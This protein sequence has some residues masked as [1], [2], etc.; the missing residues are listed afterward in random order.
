MKNVILLTS[1]VFI[2]LI[3]YCHSI[4]HYYIIILPFICDL[5][6]I[7]NTVKPVVTSIKGSMSS[8]PFSGHLY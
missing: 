5:I 4:K 2:E 3:M 1:L 7:P 6:E 8:P